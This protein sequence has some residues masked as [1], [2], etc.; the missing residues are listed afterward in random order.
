MCSEHNTYMWVVD[1]HNLITVERLWSLQCNHTGCLASADRPHEAPDLIGSSRV[2]AHCRAL[3][4]T[5]ADQ[6]PLIDVCRFFEYSGLSANVL[7]KMLKISLK[8]GG[9]MT[10]VAHLFTSRTPG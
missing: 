10:L 6:T 8:F 4:M 3:L 7:E 9:L 2:L 5:D 1:L